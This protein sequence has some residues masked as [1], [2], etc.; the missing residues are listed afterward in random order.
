MIGL[1]RAKS[2]VTEEQQTRRA[3]STSSRCHRHAPRTPRI[4]FIFAQKPTASERKRNRYILSFFILKEQNDR[5]TEKHSQDVAALDHSLDCGLSR[6]SGRL[7]AACILQCCRYFYFY[8]S[9]LTSVS[10][11]C[12]RRDDARLGRQ[13]QCTAID[14]LFI[15]LHVFFY[16]HKNQVWK[17]L[18]Y[19][20]F[21]IL[22]I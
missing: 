14:L 10:L 22:I 7:F 8:S 9:F 1:A 19:W 21:V 16:M 2:R 6:K 4:S 12:G 20:C 17:G 5:E 13:E 15:G 18:T 11:L 3:A